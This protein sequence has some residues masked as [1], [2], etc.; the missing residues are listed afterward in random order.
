MLGCSR[1]GGD[2]LCIQARVTESKK[3]LIYT[4]VYNVCFRKKEGW[5]EEQG[6][7]VKANDAPASVTDALSFIQNYIIIL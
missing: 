7:M 6:L 4:A 5:G 2:L 3:N 1:V